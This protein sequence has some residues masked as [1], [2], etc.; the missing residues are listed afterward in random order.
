MEIGKEQYEFASQWWIPEISDSLNLK[1]PSV[2]YDADRTDYSDK[3][4]FLVHSI[5]QF[6]AYIEADYLAKI[7]AIADKGALAI[8]SIIEQPS[9]EIYLYN[10]TADEPQLPIPVLVVA[11]KHHKAIKEQASQNETVKVLI[12]GYYKTNAI[13]KNIIATRGNTDNPVIVVSTPLSGWF[14]NAAERGPGLSV[15]LAFADWM[16]SNEIEGNF[17]FVAA[18][19]HELSHIGANSFKN[20]LLSQQI[21]NV[22][23]T[24]ALL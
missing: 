2:G 16:S 22:G 9:G 12:K 3:I 11:A 17:L 1:A 15:F 14:V 20:W 6:G 8:I 7:R 5:G 23:F 13:S 10:V 4:V 19:G 21:P 24:L 18:G